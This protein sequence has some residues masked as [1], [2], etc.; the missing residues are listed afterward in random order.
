MKTVDYPYLRTLARLLK[1]RVT[2]FSTLNNADLEEVLRLTYDTFAQ[3]TL[4]GTSVDSPF[5]YRVFLLVTDPYNTVDNAFVLSV[6]EHF[7][8]YSATSDLR[9][10]QRLC[11]FGCVRVVAAYFV[12]AYKEVFRRSKNVED[13]PAWLVTVLFD[14]AARHS[15]SPDVGYCARISLDKLNKVPE[16]GA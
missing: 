2:D 1:Y 14:R 9:L 12:H 10:E 4:P 8:D 16:E 11:G 7:R 13:V 15:D 3:L 6:C 5:M